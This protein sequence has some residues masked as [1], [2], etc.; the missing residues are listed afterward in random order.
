MSTAASPQPPPRGAGWPVRSGAVPPLA[1]CFNPRPE[2][3]TG[4]AST[5]AN[6]E[7][8]VLAR[9]D[10][11]DGQLTAEL[12]GTGKTQ[13]AA[14]FAHSAWRAGTVDLLTW[15]RAGRRD[16]VLCGYAAALA[17][18]GEPD[19]GTDCEASAARFVAWLAR[20]SRPW[21]VVLDDLANLADL[22]GLWPQGAAGRVLVTTRLPAAA[23]RGRGVPDLKIHQVGAFSPRE[24]LGYLIERLDTNAGQRTEAVDL[25]ADLGCLPLA[26]AQAS[27][28]LADTGL[29]CRE[30]RAHY[31]ER[32]RR[33]GVSAPGDAATVAITWTLSMDRADLLAPAGL[34]RPALALIA[35]LGSA[36]IPAQV[37]A[38]PASCGYIC[39]ADAA[40]TD[41]DRGRVRTALDNLE[42]AGLV[43]LDPGA[44]A[45]AVLMHGLVRAAILR[46]MPPTVL[47]QAARAAADALLQAWPES[48]PSEQPSAPGAQSE[49]A[50]RDCAASLLRS[51]G[52]L[53]WP[54]EPH[55]VLLRAGRSLSS[56]R[57]T[58][59]AIAYW[60]AM[61]E[62][63]GRILGPGHP[64]TLLACDNLAATYAAAGRAD[65]ATVAYG[66]CLAE[67]EEALGPDH[68]DTLT[69]RASLARACLVAGRHPD[70]VMLYERT[71]AD[72]EG[73][74]GPDHPDTLTS[75]AELGSA[76]RTAGRITEAV[77]V[78]RRA[79]ADCERLIPD[80]PLTLAVREN[81]EAASTAPSS[82]R[83]AHGR[84]ADWYVLA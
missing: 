56:A 20:T 78:L 47:E 5:L 63:G 8:A 21:L 48:T 77:A 58:G 3:G 32:R 44:P 33:L 38:S 51:A 80:H 81:L 59:P 83:A 69:S 62:T 45:R 17:A 14:A 34:A 72:R 29:G 19:P 41:A 84:R 67:R 6:G 50:L 25:A 18:I 53:L 2:T 24:A 23:L 43:T 22:N 71:L 42:R 76:Y 31:A 7:T 15:V 26:L 64:T 66:R 79:L 74:L 16:A 30:Y 61:I 1:N 65:E 4:P 73:V 12:G 60:Q 52:D 37:L 10:S 75:R 13:L 49:Q 54:P 55:P 36:G 57:L 82:G 28:V 27:A 70:A 39:G 9:P 11:A 68:P 40:G 46:V 35:L